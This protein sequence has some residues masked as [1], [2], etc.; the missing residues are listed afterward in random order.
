MCNTMKFVSV[1]I[2]IVIIIFVVGLFV[3]NKPKGGK[4]DEDWF[5]ELF[6]NVERGDSAVIFCMAVMMLIGTFFY[7]C[8]GSCGFNILPLSLLA[9]CGICNKKD[10]GINEA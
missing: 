4:I 5:K 2:A 6:K 10:D 9:L 3:V 1:T 7:A 8:Y